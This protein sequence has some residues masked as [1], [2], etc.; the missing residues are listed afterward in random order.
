VWF[1]ANLMPKGDAVHYALPSSLNYLTEHF[2]ANSQLSAYTDHSMQ[3]TLEN[4]F[5]LLLA[6]LD[7]TDLT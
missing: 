4:Y 6:C 3:R 7:D 1:K 5:R 2:Q